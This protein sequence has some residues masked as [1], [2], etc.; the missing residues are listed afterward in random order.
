MVTGLIDHSWDQVDS[1]NHVYPHL[2]IGVFQATTTVHLFRAC[3][4]YWW[5]ESAAMVVEQ[6]QDMRSLTFRAVM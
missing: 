5:A 6:V 3:V 2:A 1:S 4:S